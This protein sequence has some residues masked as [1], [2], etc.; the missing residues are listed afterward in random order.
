MPCDCTSVFESNFTFETFSHQILSN[1]ETVSIYK[2]KNKKK[3]PYVKDPIFRTYSSNSAWRNYP[4]IIILTKCSCAYFRGL[5]NDH[6]T[7]VVHLLIHTYCTHDMRRHF[8]LSALYT[9]ST[10]YSLWGVSEKIDSMSKPNDEITPSMWA[11]QH[12]NNDILWHFLHSVRERSWDSWLLDPDN[13]PAHNAKNIRQFLADKDISVLERPSDMSNL[14]LRDLFS[15]NYF[16]NPRG[17]SR[18]PVLETWMTS[19]WQWWWSCGGSWKNPS[20]SAWPRGTEG[21]EN[22]LDSG[23]ITWNEKT[24]NLNLNYIFCVTPPGVFFTDLVHSSEENGD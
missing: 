3:V 10:V 17:S 5:H 11:N 18:D 13:T 8:R 21:W 23:G 19:R 4:T 6:I 14:V 9:V 20:A 22:V 7:F 24:H 12:I 1:L 15:P 2:N 16:P